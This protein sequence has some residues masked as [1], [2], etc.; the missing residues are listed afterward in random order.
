MQGFIVNRLIVIV[1]SNHQR[2][3]KVSK[4]FLKEDE[5]VFIGSNI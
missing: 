4:V 2:A 3:L 5:R 1:N